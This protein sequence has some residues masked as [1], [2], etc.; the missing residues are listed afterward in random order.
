MFAGRA[1]F[2]DPARKRG[3][4]KDDAMPPAPVYRPAARALHWLSALLILSTIPAGVIML[5]DGLSRPLQDS[6]FMFHKNIGV[7][8]LL[9]VLARIAYRLANPP[10]PLPATVPTLQARVAGL[11]HVLLYVVLIVM[12]VSGYVRVVAGGFPLEVWD[13]LGVPRLLEKSEPLANQAKAIH[14]T[15][16]FALI[17]LIGLHLGGAAYHA[18][19]LKDGVMRRMWPGRA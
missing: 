15:A 6:L 14:A 19:I 1:G 3:N 11:V 9:L 8:I 4:Q 18:L 13:A 17:A 5:Q 7:V 10:P 16:R 2:D 12:A